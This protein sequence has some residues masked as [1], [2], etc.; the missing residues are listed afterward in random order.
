MAVLPLSVIIT[1]VSIERSFA[2]VIAAWHIEF[3]LSLRRNVGSLIYQ[4]KFH[5]SNQNTNITCHRN[6]LKSILDEKKLIRNKKF[7]YLVL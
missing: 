6:I 3:L 7:H 1:I 5:V 4:L 2:K